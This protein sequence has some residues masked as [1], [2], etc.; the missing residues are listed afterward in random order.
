MSH[1]ALASA[2]IILLTAA[3]ALAGDPAQFGIVDHDEAPA[4]KSKPEPAA[5]PPV[6]KKERG[7]RSAPAAARPVERARAQP[8]AA[9]AETPAHSSSAAPATYGGTFGAGAIFG[10]PTGLTAK[11]WLNHSRDAIDFGL[12]YSVRNYLMLY[13]DKLWHFGRLPHQLSAYFGGGAGLF[14][15][16]DTRVDLRIPVGVEW[17]PSRPRIGVFAEL[18]P[19]LRVAPSTGFDLN[20]G[21]GVRYYF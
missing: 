5:A 13:A 17:L 11:Y 9:S 4:S 12:A 2:T 20:G 8:S 7:K 16:K 19:A 15:G 3:T 10:E 21:V 1:R 14:L 18:V 6:A